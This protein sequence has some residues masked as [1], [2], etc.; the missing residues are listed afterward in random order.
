[1]GPGRKPRRPV[2]SQRGSID[3]DDKQQSDNLFGKN[4]FT[5][6]NCDALFAPICNLPYSISYFSFVG[7]TSL[8]IVPIP[9]HCLP[10]TFVL[11]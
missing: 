2:F 8:L 7:R 1:M 9:G 6:I 5:L 11:K 3:A 10:F 4:L